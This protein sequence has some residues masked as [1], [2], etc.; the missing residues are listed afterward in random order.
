[1]KF[2]SLV[3]KAVV[4][5]AVATIAFT[6]PA[7]ASSATGSFTASCNPTI[8]T[9]NG[10][11]FTHAATG[12][13]SVKQTASNPTITSTVNLISQNGNTVGAKNIGDGSTATW[14]SVL[15]GQYRIQAKSASSVNCNGIL[16]GNGNYNFSYNITY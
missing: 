8:N 9:T 3:V 6:A 10:T 14:S 1:M 12:A 7:Y 5:T 4:V 11:I 15:T 2:N 13:M 16:P